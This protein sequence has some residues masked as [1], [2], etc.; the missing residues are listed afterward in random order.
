MAYQVFARKYRPQNFDE[1]IGQNPVVTTLK[2]AIQLGRIHHAYL[3]TG[4]R[5]VGKTSLARI[6]AKSLNCEK[7]PTAS[8]CQTCEACRGITKGNSMDV[9]EIDGASNTGVDD[10]RELREQAKY[11]PSGGKNKIYIIDEVH[12]LSISAFNALLK[13]LEEPPPH[14]LFLFATTEPHKIPVTILSRCQR[15]DL[16][17]VDPSVLTTHLQS[18]LEKENI[19]MDQGSLALIIHCG[20]GSVRDSL[21]LLDQT[22]GYCGS[23]LTEDKVRELLGLADRA[24]L[25]DCVE[26]LLK[27]PSQAILKL[28]QTLFEK[29][30][31]L[32]IFSEGLLE[33]IRN[34]MV[35]R[36]GGKEFLNVAPG[37]IHWFEKAPIRDTSFLLMIFQILAKGTEELARSSFPRLIFETTLLKMMHAQDW[38]SLPELLGKAE[39][40]HPSPF[41]AV[42]QKISSGDSLVM[43][44]WQAF[45]KKVLEVKPQM[46]SLMEHAYPVEISKEK[47]SFGFDQPLYADM[48]KDRMTQLSEMAKE[49]FHPGIQI[50]I[51]KGVP[52]QKGKTVLAVRLEEE[53]RQAVALK[54]RVLASPAIQA[55]EKILGAKFKEVK[56]L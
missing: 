3:F 5:G 41:P 18:I 30:I 40:S 20:E 32:K 13:I 46:G 44:S 23:E 55:A 45:V 16:R 21:S 37:D 28:S 38:L 26:A 54:E 25:Y 50:V 22:V 6:L 19:S 27:G 17:R 52:I 35:Y 49:F 2:N 33:T 15:F 29:G 42:G 36:E 7:G 4:A 11:L 48:L 34:L 43:P 9:L 1:V 31:D 39:K 47:L 8:P 24:L 53:Q 12:M 10:V 51:E 14:L 56:P